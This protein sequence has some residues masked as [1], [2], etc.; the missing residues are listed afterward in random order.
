MA[1]PTGEASPEAKIFNFNLLLMCKLWTSKFEYF[2]LISELCAIFN[3]KVSILITRWP[4]TIKAQTQLNVPLMKLSRFHFLPPLNHIESHAPWKV[5]PD[6]WSSANDFL[7]CLLCVSKSR[8]IHHRGWLNHIRERFWLVCQ[9]AQK[10]TSFKFLF[11]HQSKWFSRN[12]YIR[13][14]EISIFFSS[15]SSSLVRTMSVQQ[16][17]I[18]IRDCLSRRFMDVFNESRLSCRERPDCECNSLAVCWN[19]CQRLCCINHANG[20]GIKHKLVR[21][22]SENDWKVHPAFRSSS[23]HS[24]ALSFTRTCNPP[25]KNE[26]SPLSA[27]SFYLRALVNG[28][29]KQKSKA[30]MCGERK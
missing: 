7:F 14:R 21:I 6:L 1:I 13:V 11:L 18:E 9:P 29:R 15:E 8:D 24:K 10:R 26:S 5:S 3:L 17:L 16:I 25:K 20:F 12:G 4:W 30:D 28:T 19:Q 2:Y 27:K 23:K 22:K